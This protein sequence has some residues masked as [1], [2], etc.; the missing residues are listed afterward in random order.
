MYRNSS[1]RQ[2]AYLCTNE[3]KVTTEKNV[4]RLNVDFLSRKCHN[5]STVGEMGRNKRQR[6]RE[7]RT[8]LAVVR[9]TR[10]HDPTLVYL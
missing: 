9:R 8:I 10:T 7:V 4:H 3:A 5:C 1:I 2:V 6:R